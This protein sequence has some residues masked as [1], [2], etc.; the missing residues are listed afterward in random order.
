[1]SICTP[2]RA[3]TLLFLY[4]AELIVRAHN[5]FIHT[6]NKTFELPSVIKLCEYQRIP[7]RDVE[8]SKKNIF[9]R[10]GGKC[11]Y[12]GSAKGILT[13]DHIMPK[14]RG[15]ESSWENLT[16]ACFN[17]N[18]KKSNKTPFEAKMPLLSKPHKPNYVLYLNQK[19]GNVKDEW[20]QFLFV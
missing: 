19:I 15:G 8:L 2:K 9:R 10:D 5:K 13:I 12:C 11:Q 16:T 20:Q 17:C 1:M 7:Y 4:K 18:N 6:V 14:S 3:I